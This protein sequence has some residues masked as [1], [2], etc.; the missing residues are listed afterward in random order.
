MIITPTYRYFSSLIFASLL[1]RIKLVSFGILQWL[2]HLYT[3][4]DVWS[5]TVKWI[6]PVLIRGTWVTSQKLKRKTCICNNNYYFNIVNRTPTWLTIKISFDRASLSWNHAW[7]RWGMNQIRFYS[8]AT[9]MIKNG[10]YWLGRSSA[11][12]RMDLC[13]RVFNWVCTARCRKWTVP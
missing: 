5:N 3:P 12:I 7:L 10:R 13:N 1:N 8:L 6:L 2:M 4:V 9:L 11:S